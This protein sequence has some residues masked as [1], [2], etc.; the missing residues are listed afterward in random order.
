MGRSPCGDAGLIVRLGR[1]ST[2]LVEAI[3]LKRDVIERLRPTLL[4]TMGLF[5]ALR[6]CFKHACGRDGASCSAS[7]PS[8]EIRLASASLSNIFRV[9]QGL[10]DCTF[11]EPALCTV[12]LNVIIQGN[13]LL[14]RLAHSHREKEVTDVQERFKFELL[15]AAHRTASLGAELSFEHLPRGLQF[16]LAVPLSAANTTFS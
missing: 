8:Q 7:L 12:D 1:L 2:S 10:L 13:M 4:D 9:T 3:R 11:L 14:T 5:E 6:W 16:Q 15:S